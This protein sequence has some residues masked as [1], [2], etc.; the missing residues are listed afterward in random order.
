[1]PFKLFTVTTTTYELIVYSTNNVLEI[2]ETPGDDD[3]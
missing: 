3:E 1:M 2:H